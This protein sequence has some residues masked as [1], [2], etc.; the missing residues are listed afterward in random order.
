MMREDLKALRIDRDQ[1]KS[2]SRGPALWLILLMG[3]FL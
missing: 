3:L 2:G 1:K